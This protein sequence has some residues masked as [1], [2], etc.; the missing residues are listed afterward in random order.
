MTKHRLHKTWCYIHFTQLQMDI[1]QQEAD[2]TEQCLALVC[3]HRQVAVQCNEE[4]VNCG[5]KPGIALADAWLL[6]GSLKYQL[7][8]PELDQVL[9]ESQ[10]LTLYPWFAD[11]AIDTQDTGLWIHLHSQQQLHDDEN[12]VEQRLHELLE[13]FTHSIAFASNPTLAKLGVDDRNRPLMDAVAGSPIQ[14]ADLGSE[15]EQKLISMGL[16]T[17]DKVLRIP[18]D[19]LGKKLGQEIVQWR[20]NV[21]GRSALNLHYYHPQTSFYRHR[22]LD[23][24]I[25]SWDGIRFVLKSLLETLQ[26]FLRTHQKATQRVTVILFSRGYAHNPVYP[27]KLP[28]SEVTCIDIT[29]ARPCTRATE[30]FN[31][32][33]LQ[34]EATKFDRPITD[35]AL[36]VSHLE[37]LRSINSG[38]WVDELADDGLSLVLNRLQAKL[39]TQKVRRLA[40]QKGWLP[41]LQ[42]TFSEAGAALKTHAHHAETWVPLW[43]V[44][45][46][47]IDIDAWHLQGQPQRLVVPWWLAPQPSQLQRDYWVA[48]DYLGRYGWVYFEVEAEQSGRWFLQG[49]VS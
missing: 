4:A 44:T 16:L 23:A 32:M 28:N 12:A 37:S 45:P 5:I 21:S 48:Q 25:V 2:L 7:Y 17:L 29:M 42:Q 19:V 8:Q 24:D 14:D 3:E 11:I 41:E 22:Q 15:L 34:M 26:S 10:A 6:S 38:F 46:Q 30:I 9:L 49:W 20:L 31:V 36:Q 47:P 35:I 43:L 1:W 39:G 33:Q 18:L 40:P 27:P 13:S